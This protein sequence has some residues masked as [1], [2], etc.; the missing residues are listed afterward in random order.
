MVLSL[1]MIKRAPPVGT[2]PGEVLCHHNAKFVLSQ[3]DACSSEPGEQLARFTL[4][5]KSRTGT[6]AITV[7]AEAGPHQSSAKINLAVRAQNPPLATIIRQEV[8]P[9]AQ[10]R[11]DIKPFGIANTT[12]ATLEVSRVPP[13]NL[14]QRLGY[15]IQYP[16][17]CLEQTT[18]AAFPQLYLNELAQLDETTQKRIE[19]NI[20]AGIERLNSFQSGGQGF[21]YWPGGGEVNSWANNY[22]GHFLVE[23]KKLGYQVPP[24]MYDGWLDF[25][26]AAAT[27]WAPQGFDA[28]ENQAYRLYTLALADQP[29][30]GAMN[31]L[32]EDKHLSSLARWNLAAA[33]AQMGLPDAAKAIMT[34][35]ET[36]NAYPAPGD[37]FGSRTRDD[38]VLL[39]TLVL[40]GDQVQAQRVA[41]RL[42][43]DLSTDAWYS[44]QS[45]AYALMGMA[46]FGGRLG[47]NETFS[48]QFAEGAGKAQSV[49]AKKA[50]ASQPLANS[51]NG[52]A[53]SFK[54]T[55]A[56]RLFVS[57]ILR[58]SPLPGEEKA[59]SDGLSLDVDY[60]GV[61]GA[62]VDIRKL[63][64]GSDL[65]A[66][67]AITNRS[68]VALT[69]LALTQVVAA[70]WEISNPR[71]ASGAEE[72]PVELDYQ[73]IRDD[74][75]LSYFKLA[76]GET[77]RLKLLLNASYRGR[78]YLPAVTVES[79]YDAK[80]QA[81]TAGQW[82]EVVP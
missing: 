47:N 58:G 6:G 56:Q 32:R 67:I 19:G 12:Q 57:L 78:Y 9:A 16:H 68:G 41:E 71:F 73:D 51:A 74:R 27:R 82:V 15:L 7:R 34:Q 46:R 62:A 1:F 53:F 8:E 43:T 30:V 63:A 20:K 70:G 50:L 23:A 2:H 54:N 31:R 48:F 60:S 66:S 44:T 79:M 33:Y 77:K 4:T 25:Q 17:G 59:A 38:G 69:D 36:P 24:V 65:V 13:I 11:S 18:S 52:G 75:V 37:T 10:W 80:K 28:V 64:Q 81:R 40:L 26:K 39:S 29:D 49:T 22:A 45:T 14:E 35:R 3:H 42:S 76:P 5:A 55:S 21:V 61:D 72:K